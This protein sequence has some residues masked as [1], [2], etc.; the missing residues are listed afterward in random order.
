M[1]KNGF[2][3]RTQTTT[4]NPTNVNIQN[5][6]GLFTDCNSTFG[7][8][9]QQSQS[10][11]D[12]EIIFAIVTCNITNLKRFV[13]SS[14]I[15]NIIDK[16]NKYTALHYAVIIKKN[17][18]IIEYLMSCGA[19][20]SIKQDEGKDAI[21][22]SIESNY[23]FLIDKLLKNKDGELDNLYLKYDKLSYKFKDLEKTNQELSKT[24]EYLMKSSNEY[25]EKIEYL[26][27]DNINLKRK[28]DESEKAFTN[29]LKKTK[30]N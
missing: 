19:N 23:R 13:T 6:S 15:N 29:L 10:Q 26:K 12:N 21:D 14:N 5:S 1:F 30:K 17:D 7:L 11:L 4:P 2:N 27:D 25:V 22:L 16:K 9:N 8:I 18:Q 28:F 20:P 3:S 24:N